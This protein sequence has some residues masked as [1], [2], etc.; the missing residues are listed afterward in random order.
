MT[1]DTLTASAGLWTG[2]VRPAPALAA[3]ARLVASAPGGCLLASAGP[4]GPR[5]RYV[6]AAVDPFLVVS[7]GGAPSVIR[8]AWR[9]AADGSTPAPG[10]PPEA[11]RG[12]LPP[13]GTLPIAD[14]IPLLDT[15][16]AAFPAPPAPAL[17]PFTG[18]LAGWFGYD[19]GRAFERL[20]ARAP[21]PLALPA[22]AL[23]VYD[24][25]L[26]IDR[27]TRKAMIVAT[28][29]PEREPAHRAARA[30][31]RIAWLAE[32]LAEA[33]ASPAAA[34]GAPA[35]LAA[36]FIAPGAP[37]AG[38]VARLLARGPRDEAA[39][40]RGQGLWLAPPA[41]GSAR[42]TGPA[43][44]AAGAAE[45]P[46]ASAVTSNMSRDAYLDAV[47]RVKNFI[48]KGDVYQANVTQRFRWPAP[49]DAAGW[50]ADLLERNPVPFAAYIRGF[51]VD[52]DARGDAGDGDCAP[53]SRSAAPAAYEIV[54]L[55]PE[56]FLRVSGDR[57]ETCPIKGTRPR[58]ADPREDERNARD[59]LASPKDRAELVMIV[60]LLRNDLG[61]VAAPGSVAVPELLRLES[62]ATVHHLV[63]RVTARL[64]AGARPLDALRA[65]FPGGSISGAPKIRAME[66]IDE[67][68]PHARGPF[69]GAIGYIGGNGEMDTSIA[70]RT[71]VVKDGVAHLQ[72][73]GGIVH[74]SR[75]EDEYDEALHKAA[76]FLGPLAGASESAP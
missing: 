67:V 17:P 20:P 50:F 71:V 31:A 59:L 55:S 72:V 69:M 44:L 2:A 53:T 47:H 8:L 52:G 27:L 56:R 21:D 45:A 29:Y 3:L 16:L 39:A 7:G 40:G 54:S 5:S 41:G 35:T 76:A 36:T 73:G 63:A 30:R 62:Y 37:P 60:D 28:G 64:A 43:G 61:R 65:A 24:L 14:P 58:G 4:V 19:L 6:F 22:F 10:D 12:G 66:I 25:V 48:R 23:G 26:A 38:P 75:A 9:G 68:E 33:S 1:N 15:I 49:P 18:G 32:R 34:P 13:S 11:L 46:A 57:I 70:I 74:D 51:G 42:A